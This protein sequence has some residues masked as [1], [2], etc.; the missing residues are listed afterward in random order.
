ERIGNEGCHN[1]GVNAVLGGA[2]RTNGGFAVRS[3]S[4][5]RNMLTIAGAVDV[6][7]TAAAFLNK[8]H[9]DTHIKAKAVQQNVFLCTAFLC[10]C[11]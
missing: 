11:R 9:K 5:L 7:F 10:I 3:A 2:A 1:L 6:H 4:V 8:R